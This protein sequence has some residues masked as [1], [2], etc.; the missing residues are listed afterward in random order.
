M[1]LGGAASLPIA[2][3]SQQPAIPVIGFLN[4]QSPGSFAHLADAFRRGLSEAGFTEGRNV[5]IEYRWAEG[6]NDRLPE[7]A[8]DL[9]RRQV[10]V[11]VA[12]G[13]EPAA[14]AA[15]APTSTIPIVFAIG[16]DPVRGRFVASFNHPG[17]NMTGLTQFTEQL[18]GKRLALLHEL[19]PNAAIAAL[20]NP[21]SPLSEKQ[22]KDLTE[23][24]AHLNV[25]LIPLFAKTESEFGPAFRTVAEQ[26][27]GGILVTADPFF[28]GRRER[29]VE[30]AAARKLP[31]IYEF[32]EFA[33]AGGLMSYGTS[34]ADG[35]RQVGTYV[36][37]I[38]NGA[39]PADLTVLQPTKFEFVINLKVAAALGL[40]I[41]PTLLARAD[42][43]IE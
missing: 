38:L 35:Y 9:V 12:T 41:P 39:K 13:G 33:A 3:R 28:N 4:S 34:L 30:L 17:S 11:L 42:E 10:A 26:K 32:R 37:K 18:E 25:L 7:Q 31:V 24:A 43:V 16:G 19:L 23:A 21:D 27:A 2:A 22:L 15:K 20:I 29:L 40:E 1:A 14:L 5:A 8:A 6:H 36:G